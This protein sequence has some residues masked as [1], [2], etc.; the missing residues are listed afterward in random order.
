MMMTT[1]WRGHARNR[2]TLSDKEPTFMKSKRNTAVAMGVAIIA[3]AGGIT[4]AQHNH[5]DGAQAESP[6]SALAVPSSIQE[7]HTHLHHQLD[8]ALASG[9]KTAEKAR[10]VADVLASHFKQEEAFAMPPLGLLQSLAHKKAVDEADARKAIDMATRLRQ[11]Y[12]AMLKEHRALTEALHALAAAAR[13]EGKPA[14]AH[15]AEALITHAQNEEQILY[16]ATLVI[17]E[18]LTL[19]RDKGHATR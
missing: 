2:K 1:D 5:T 3:L 10:V 8:A 12:D 19:L 15:F 4:W 6:K 17:G 13:E 16:P 7:E 14:H 18:Y 9:G 11:E